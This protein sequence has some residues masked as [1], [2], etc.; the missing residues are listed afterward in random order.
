M[1]FFEFLQIVQQLVIAG[2][3]ATFKYRTYG[4]TYLA[5]EEHISTGALVC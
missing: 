1:S 2:E 3:Q 4:I 5:Q